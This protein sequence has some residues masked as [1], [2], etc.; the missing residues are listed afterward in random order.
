[1]NSRN[2]SDV[3]IDGAVVACCESQNK[4]VSNSR[5]PTCKEG[6]N[7]FVWDLTEDPPIKLDDGLRKRKYEPFSK[8]EGG[9]AGAKVQPGNYLV[10]L[11]GW[12][13][14]CGY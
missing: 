10:V 6:L 4:K 2:L 5:R 9:P 1:M 14:I 11:T 7:R 8:S 12:F 3:Q 13:I